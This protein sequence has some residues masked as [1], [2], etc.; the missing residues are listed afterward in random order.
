MLLEY[1]NQLSLPVGNRSALAVSE[2]ASVKTRVQNA[3][4]IGASF[5]CAKSSSRLE[6]CT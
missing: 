6:S 5:L 2:R 1:R 3:F 4:A